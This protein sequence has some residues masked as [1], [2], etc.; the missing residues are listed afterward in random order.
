[1]LMLA[2]ARAQ[3]PMDP[4]LEPM[5]DPSMGM[6]G[7]PGRSFE[8]EQPPEPE[9]YD[10]SNFPS[11]GVL[12]DYGFGDPSQMSKEGLAPGAFGE[13]SAPP[14]R[15]QQYTQM[16]DEMTPPP[17]PGA[18]VIARGLP[19]VAGAFGAGLGLNAMMGSTSDADEGPASELAKQQGKLRARLEDT[20]A[21]MDAAENGSRDGKVGRGKDWR[22]LK[23][24]A[25]QIESEISGISAQIEAHRNSPEYQQDM[26]RRA[27]EIAAD[28]KKKEAATPW[29]DRNPGAAAALPAVGMGLAFALPG[30]AGIKKQAGTLTKGGFAARL[31]DAIQTA[32][33]G[34]ASGKVT[35]ETRVA[36]GTINNILKQEPKEGF[37][38]TAKRLGAT[39]GQTAAAGTAGGLLS[40]EASLYPDQFDAYNLPDGPTKDKA[41]ERALDPKNYLERGAIGSITGMSG[42]KA[43]KMLTPAAKPNWEKGASVSDEVA[44]LVSA[45][46]RT[47]KALAKAKNAK[48]KAKRKTVDG[49]PLKE[50]QKALPPPDKREFIP[51]ERQPSR[52]GMSQKELNEKLTDFA[53]AWFKVNSGKKLKSTHILNIAKQ[54]DMDMSL[55][56]ATRLAGRLNKT[57][58]TPQGGDKYINAG[59]KAALTKKE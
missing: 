4:G 51:G 25:D 57:Y 34:I 43:G 26:D 47:A 10:T 8:L 16:L 2:K 38:E 33:R 19:K 39:A 46:E 59:A 12:P 42:Y 22:A 45:E 30:M 7:D 24:E 55:G 32:E 52:S 3:Q 54:N 44:R 14:E 49:G 1:M 41:R 20:R 27:K 50:E 13:I 23:A 35:P 9:S 28:L 37:M 36:A 5:G 56:Q 21:K 6:E 53:D 40:A 31:E 17:I 15:P 48:A 29:R 58:G 18:G 11:G